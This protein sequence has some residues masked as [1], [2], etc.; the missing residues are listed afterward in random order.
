[1]NAPAPM[2]APA[3]SEAQ[4][5]ERLR[6]QDG[7]PLVPPPALHGLLGS[8]GLDPAKAQQATQM[9]Q[10]AQTELA[11]VPSYPAEERLFWCF[12]LLASLYAEQGA[13]PNALQLAQQTLPSLRDVRHRQ[14]A[15][16][17]ITRYSALA[18]DHATAQ[19]MLAQLDPA[20]EDLQ[21]DTNYRFS[22]AY[23]AALRGD[24]NAVLQALGYNAT[25]IPISDA[26]DLVCAVLRANA[27]ERQ[28]RLDVARAQML[29]LASTNKGMASISEIARKNHELGLLGATLP[30]L[31]QYV[32]KLHQNVVQT[33]SGIS[34]GGF[35]ILP[36]IGIVVF[37]GGSTL[38]S[39][40]PLSMQ[41]IV[42]TIAAVG[43]GVLS[44]LLVTRVLF[45][46]ARVRKQLAKTGTSAT[47]EI[48]A[49][50][51]TGTR[52]NHQPMYRFRMLI[53]IPGRDPYL[54]LHNEVMAPGR[55]QQLPPGTRLRV[56]V[57]PADPRMMAI[58]WN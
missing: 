7:K 19:A 38:L 33:K 9:W 5:F 40:L 51:T 12:F 23:T 22:T 30:A 47:G 35:F 46:G 25:D 37:G 15:M 29:P 53:D 4:R 13:R 44:L 21:I 3:M 11:S 43:F 28:G 14:I 45:R 17:S 20:S 54:A 24:D 27:H 6:A 48:L 16:G 32:E 31:Q 50:E 42:I 26:Y 57:D 56:M 36:V 55:V 49:I 10:A 2:G 1:M 8:G 34:I 41:P 39:R 52:V 58:A 18:G